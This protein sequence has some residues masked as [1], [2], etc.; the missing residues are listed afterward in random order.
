[1]KVLILSAA[2]LIVS[3]VSYGQTKQP[4]DPVA[5]NQGLQYAP[6]LPAK[7]SYKVV[8][9]PLEIVL[10]KK[11]LIEINKHRKANEDFVWKVENGV[12]ILIYKRS[13]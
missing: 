8:K 2:F 12:E 5:T 13:H 3:A 1:M 9:N 10:S 11:T 6:Q 7:T 4:V